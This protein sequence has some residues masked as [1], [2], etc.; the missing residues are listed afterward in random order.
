[1]K[2]QN[3]NKKEGQQTENMVTNMVVTNMVVINTV[4]INLPC[5]YIPI[6][7]LNVNDQQ[8]P[9]R[10]QRLLDQKVIP[11]FMLSKNKTKL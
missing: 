6:V 4:D 9:S 5:H 11:D 3:R 10:R 7:I 2:N 8:V 1:M